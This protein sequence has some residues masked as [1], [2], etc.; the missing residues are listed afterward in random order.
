MFSKTFEA[1]LF[2]CKKKNM[3]WTHWLLCFVILVLK[4]VNYDGMSKNV[5]ECGFQC[6][7]NWMWTAGEDKTVK[8][9][10]LR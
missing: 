7:G 1:R 9:W 4:V 8:I 10:D 2:S 3:K 5:M 6:D